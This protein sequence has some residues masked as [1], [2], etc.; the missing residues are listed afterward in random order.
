MILNT[1]SAYGPGEGV[2][3]SGLQL[4]QDGKVIPLLITDSARYIFS[5]IINNNIIAFGVGSQHRP[6]FYDIEK[7]IIY[8]NGVTDGNTR[9]FSV[10][11]YDG[12]K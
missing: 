1:S 7:Y 4:Y 8:Q 9:S 2:S 10:I 6:V 5:P 3:R 12:L 11:G